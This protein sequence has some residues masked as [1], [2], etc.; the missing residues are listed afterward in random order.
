MKTLVVVLAG[1]ADR[2]LEDLGGRTP[3]EAAQTPVLDRLGAEGRVGRVAIAPEGMRPEEGAFALALYGLDPRAYG[4]IGA[5]LEAAGFGV[6]VGSLDQAFRL[7]LVTAD[8][9]TVYDPTAGHVSAEEASTLLGALA[10]ACADPDLTFH[11]G[12]GWRNLLV[13]KG[14]RDVRVRTVP[15]FDVVGKALSPAMPRGT[16]IGRL[17]AVVERSADVLPAHEVNE[18][19]RDLGENPATLAWPWGPGVSVPLPDLRARTGIA[20]AVVGTNPTVVGA[21]LLQRVERVPV[22]GATGRADT[23]LAAKASAALEALEDHDLVLLHVDSLA[24]CSYTRDFVGKVQL[25]ERADGY[26]LH[27]LVE[28][29][30]RDGA[31]RLVVVLGEAVSAESGRH[32]PDPVPFVLFGPGVRGHG[33]GAPTEVGARD[34]GFFVEEG[35][36]L[37]EFVLHLPA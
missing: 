8:A 21:G 2:P 10:D 32:L 13:W 30:R 33:R 15:P 23:A 3:L 18:C 20:A 29:V 5:V 7:A 36:E 27:P 12:T 17:L 25:L 4:E 22:S 31:T 6:P 9:T 16:G 35:H 11:P 34:G 1:A 26:L 19:R 14:A 28:A 37:L 24:S